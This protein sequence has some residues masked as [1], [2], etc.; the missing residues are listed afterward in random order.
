MKSN[1]R[2]LK[3]SRQRYSITG[4]S[5]IKVKLKKPKIAFIYELVDNEYQADN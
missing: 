3:P 4:K 1:K 5:L 2:K